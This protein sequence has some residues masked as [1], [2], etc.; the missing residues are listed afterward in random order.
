MLWLN[1][2]YGIPLGRYILATHP[3]Y[4]LDWCDSGKCCTAPV[5]FKTLLTKAP[6]S[7]F[8]SDDAHSVLYYYQL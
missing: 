7:V 8:S 5:M 2:E 3:R 6:T 4:L 1:E